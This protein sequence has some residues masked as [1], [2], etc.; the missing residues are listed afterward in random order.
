MDSTKITYIRKTFRHVKPH[1][2][3]QLE[4][5]FNSL[6]K[7]ESTFWDSTWHRK[8]PWDKPRV[9]RQCFELTLN[10]DLNICEAY[11]EHPRNKRQT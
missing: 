4:V 2:I 5:L 10:C 3:F 8:N 11:L 7:I 9:S 1:E 6:E